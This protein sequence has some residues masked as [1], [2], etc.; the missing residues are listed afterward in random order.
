MPPHTDSESTHTIMPSYQG[1]NISRLTVLARN[2]SQVQRLRSNFESERKAHRNQFY[3]SIIRNDRSAEAMLQN[4][5]RAHSDTKDLIKPK[6]NKNLVSNCEPRRRLFHDHNSTVNNSI[7]IP[8]DAED[9]F[10]MGYV[11]SIYSNFINFWV[12]S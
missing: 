9:V 4:I 7:S 5:G 8:H 11:L 10:S 12:R 6:W 2:G 3:N 1:M